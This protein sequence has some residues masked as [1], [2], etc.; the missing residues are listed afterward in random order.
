MNKRQK[1]LFVINTMGRAGAEK[2]LVEL[3][4]VLDPEKY[5]IYLYVL[6]PRGEMFRELPS[7][8]TI[9]NPRVDDRSVLS[10]GGKLFVGRKLLGAAF[11]SGSLAK[12]A[13]TWLFPGRGEKIRGEKILRRL[14]ADGTAPLPGT[15]DLAAAYLEGPATWYVAEKV[16][17]KRKVAFVHIDYGQ[18]GY[19]RELDRGCYE[20][21]H[22]IFAVSKDVRNRFLEFYPEYEEKISIFLN[23]INQDLIRR[24]AMEPG[25]LPAED[26]GFKIL[27]VGRLYYQK[28]YDIGI[29]TAALLAS[30]GYK[31]HWYALGEGEEHKSL[32]SLIRQ[33]KLEKVFVLLGAVQNPYPYFKQADLYVCTSRFE[34]KSIV[35]EEAQTLGKPIVAS[36]CTGIEEQIRDGVDGIIVPGEPEN[37]AREIARLMEDRELR[38]RLGRAAAEKEHFHSE[39]YEQFLELAEET[40]LC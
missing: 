22:K 9:L 26:T 36:N 33:L 12:A 23:I 19:S 25:G 35:I 34:G 28:G 20:K 11:H 4:R 29:R 30:R 16:R 18:A 1:V 27:T 2:A 31:F 6:I 37:L 21:F 3:I 24:R 13:G 15:F 8:V 17:A 14:V 40:A 39:G 5:H 10:L 32:Q 38:L 7:G